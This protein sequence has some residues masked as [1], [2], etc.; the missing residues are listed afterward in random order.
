M[1]SV[2]NLCF[3]ALE[4]TEHLFF[5]CKF[6]VELWN[7]LGSCL[8]CN[9]D[10]TSVFSILS[11][12]NQAWSPQVRDIVISGITNTLWFI[13]FSRNK[14]R[15]DDKKISPRAATCLALSY[16][17]LAGNLSKGHYFHST[18]EARIFSKFSVAEKLSKAPII[19][20]VIWK[21]PSYNWLKCNTYGS[22]KGIPSMAACDGLFRDKM[23]Q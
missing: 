1:V 3:S 21:A 16:T 4:T 11:L 14:I 2:C 8:A 12:C 5:Q 20:E 22:A 18:A 9:I 13:W 17:S 15:F 7:W 19:I 10:V 6:A 23:L